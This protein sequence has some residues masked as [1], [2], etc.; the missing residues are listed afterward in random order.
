MIIGAAAISLFPEVFRTFANYRM[1]IFG[2]AMILMM[3]FRPGGLWPR[4]ARR[5]GGAGPA[6]AAV[7]A[8]CLRRCA[9]P[10]KGQDGGARSSWKPVGSPRPSAGLTAVDSLDLRVHRGEISSLIGPNGAGKTTVFNVVTGIYRPEQ[11]LGALPG[12]RHHRAGSR[13]GSCSRGL[14]AHSRTSASSPT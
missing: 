8:Q 4:Q 2:V 6:A 10:R 5:H 7:E 13:T 1:V 11:R 3:M 12:E 14:R 9:R